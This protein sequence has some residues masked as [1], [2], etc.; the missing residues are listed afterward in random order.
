MKV[1]TKAFKESILPE[2]EFEIIEAMRADANQFL[3]GLQILKH[4]QHPS[5]YILFCSN[6]KDIDIQE[7]AD[8]WLKQFKQYKD[9]IEVINVNNIK[10]ELTFRLR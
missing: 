10:Q 8:K 5:E 7:V 9:R 1:N 6:T 2:T 4:K 3:Y